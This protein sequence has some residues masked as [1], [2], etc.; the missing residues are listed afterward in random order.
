MKK[1]LNIGL[2]LA[3][4]FV[5]FSA[6]STPVKAD[7]PTDRKVVVHYHR[8]DDTYDGTYIHTWGVG[9]AGVGGDIALTGTNDFGGY[10]EI[11]IDE[12][13][14]AELGL[15]LKYG[16]DW[17]DGKTDRDGWIPADGGDKINKSIEVKDENG[18]F[19]GFD[20]NGVKHVFVYEGTNE[21][22]DQDEVHG[23]LREGFGTL[24]VVYWDPIQE[25]D[26]WDIWTWETGTDG[27]VP[28]E[29][30]GI[31]FVGTIGFDGMTIGDPI[32][33][34]AHLSIASD[35]SDEIGFIV[36]TAGFA[37]KQCPDDMLVDVTDIK[38]SGHKTVFYM[39]GTCEFI[40]TF[41]EFEAIANAFEITD[42]SLNDTASFTIGF[43]KP[44]EVVED[45]VEIFDLDWFTLTD[46][47]GNPVDLASGNFVQGTDNVE[48]FT[49]FL[50]SEE[51]SGALSPYTLTFSRN[52]DEEVT[53]EITVPSTPPTISIVGGT[54]VTL[55]LGDTYSLPS[56][57]A[58][59]FVNEENL[60]L[61]NVRVKEGHGYLNTGEAGVYEIVI[62]ATDRYNNVAERTITVT[63]EGEEAGMGA[64]GI[65]LI[66]VGVAIP[67][68][69]GGTVAFLKMRRGA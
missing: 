43:N 21:V 8:W 49:L 38:G 13:A 20:E 67:V 50:D 66:S 17:G 36:R 16:A 24:S 68:L 58:T 9:T 22:L 61:Y 54:S 69:A 27:S 63:V 46:K 44:I 29:D 60:P 53:K 2:I 52:E 41:E 7:D 45:E 28:V 40:E 48:E 26:D 10:Y 15:I 23:P 25:Y 12:D 59:E 51:L 55:E 11:F 6:F 33:K 35:A 47:D 3:F 34:V 14:D 5:V 31:P 56:F 37:E 64:L 1:V 18:D 57:S 30:N 32:F 42:V 39:A 4:V 62:I 65:V 19:V